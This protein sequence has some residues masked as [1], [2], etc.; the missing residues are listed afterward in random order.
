MEYQGNVILTVDYIF[1]AE[2]SYTIFHFRLVHFREIWIHA[3]F[4]CIRPMGTD[5]AP[6]EIQTLF[7]D[8]VLHSDKH[9]VTMQH[10]LVNTENTG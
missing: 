6:S 8:S 9:Y 1:H 7:S 5:A 2:N 10:H 4:K 3:F